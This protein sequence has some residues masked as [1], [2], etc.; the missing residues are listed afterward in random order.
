MSHK[1]ILPDWRPCPACRD[2]GSELA[3][4]AGT[5]GSSRG[6][7]DVTCVEPG[8]PAYRCQMLPIGSCFLEQR[9][10]TVRQKFNNHTASTLAGVVLISIRALT[11]GLEG[12]VFKFGRETSLIESVVFLQAFKLGFKRAKVC[13]KLNTDFSL[14]RRFFSLLS[15]KLSR[16]FPFHLKQDL[17]FP[18][19]EGIADG[20]VPDVVRDL[21]KSSTFDKPYF[22]LPKF[23]F[24]ILGQECLRA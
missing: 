15:R 7:A 16:F 23:S 11:L 18:L 4:C 13:L 12:I 14:H 2:C 10:K 1:R 8:S 9:A 17:L 3:C 21:Q 19:H 5:I 22:V 20:F 24:L 6:F